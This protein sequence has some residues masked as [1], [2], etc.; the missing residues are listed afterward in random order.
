MRPALALLFALA[1]AHAPPPAPV[2][3]DTRPA[4]RGMVG[5]SV[6]HLHARIVT[7]SCTGMEPEGL[8]MESERILFACV[9]QERRPLIACE[10]DACDKLRMLTRQWAVR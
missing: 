10:A 7:R 3:P 2:A 6:S 1:C 5:E 8:V 9:M 4:I